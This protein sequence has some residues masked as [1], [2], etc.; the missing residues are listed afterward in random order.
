MVMDMEVGKVADDV[1]RPAQT[2]ADWD[3]AGHTTWRYVG[4]FQNFCDVGMCQIV[5][6]NLRTT[7]IQI[8]IE[9]ERH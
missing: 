5:V 8:E 2:G 1:D 7:I 4:Q 6:E 3:R 9:A